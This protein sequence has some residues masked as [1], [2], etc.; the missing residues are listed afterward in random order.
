MPPP[1]KRAAS[2]ADTRQVNLTP[3]L[4]LRL[5]ALVAALA[6]LV[7]AL[8]L[9]VLGRSEDAPAPAPAERAAPRAARTPARPAERRTPPVR[10]AVE[11][12]LP[13][14]LVRALARERVV[15]VSLYSPRAAS[16]RAALAEARAGAA[17][18]GAGFVAVNVLDVRQAGPLA[19]K[20]GV[21]EEPSVLV[22]RR[23]EE[24]VLRFDGYTDRDTVAQAAANA[25][26]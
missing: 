9:L 8:W 16:D 22:F 14:K 1:I 2:S 15:V 12:G 18:A 21:L 10:Q 26:A 17:R 13:V 6:A 3:A 4:Q 20:L 19:R 23:P 25:R 5:L 7:L 24:V 11:P